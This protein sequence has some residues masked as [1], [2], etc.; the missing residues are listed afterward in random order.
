VKKGQN[1]RKSLRRLKPTVGCNA[2][3]RRR[4]PVQVWTDTLRLQEVEA[5]RISRQSA[6]E[7]GKAVSPKLWPHLPTKVVGVPGTHYCY[8]LSGGPQGH[9]AAEMVGQ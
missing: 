7:G 4:I 6:H 8:S 3:K 2:S 9:R 5:P 1:G